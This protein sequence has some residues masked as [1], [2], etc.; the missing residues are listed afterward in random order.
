MKPNFT[1]N[2]GALLEAFVKQNDE[3]AF[4][5]LVDR[6]LDMVSGVAWRRTGDDRLAEEISQNVFIALANKAPRLLSRNV[7]GGWLHRVTTIEAAESMRQEYRR[8]RAMHAYKRSTQTAQQAKKAEMSLAD[9]C[10]EIDEAI[11][12]LSEKERNALMLRFHTGLGFR[13]MGETLGKTEDAC[14]KQ[15]SRALSHLARLLG[16]QRSAATL[17]VTALAAGL[18]IVFSKASGAKLRA[19]TICQGALTDFTSSSTLSPIANLLMTNLK[20]KVAAAAMIYLA[21]AGTSF[22]TGRHV[23]AKVLLASDP[24]SMSMST[25]EASSNSAI[26]LASPNPNPPKTDSTQQSIIETAANLMRRENDTAAIARG[27]LMLGEL[28]ISDMPE[29]T[30][31]LASIGDDEQLFRRMANII[32]G[33]WA[34]HDGPAAAA[35]LD[36]DVGDA[37]IGILSHTLLESWSKTEPEVAYAWY[38]QR[39]DTGTVRM[40]MLSAYHLPGNV[41]RHWM[42]NEPAAALAQ[43]TKIAVE[44]ERSARGGIAEAIY[45]SREPGPMLEAIQQMPESDVRAKLVEAVIKKWG[46]V[47][48]DTAAEWL[49]TIP[50]N[51]ELARF[52]SKMELAEE[53]VRGEIGEVAKLEEWLMK[54]APNNEMQTMVK[55][56]IQQLR[57]SDTNIH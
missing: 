4:R 12:K 50:M 31:F 45:R 32:V 7:I 43:F 54:S 14:R 53:W 49:D 41:F 9:A 2:D 28:D 19:Q 38:R 40:D 56:M 44:D 22:F 25:E 55:Q 51:D 47:E 36:S 33:I 8:Q 23:A 5:Q 21:L 3:E 13:E 1:N 15:V 52:R 20:S 34:E 27:T 11:A 16:K 46:R 10:P 48:P 35:W 24:I 18:P 37:H 29:A 6:Y 39:I 30:A 42:K 26:P 17:S 57:N